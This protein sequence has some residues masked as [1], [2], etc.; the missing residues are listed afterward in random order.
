MN[1]TKELAIKALTLYK[2][3]YTEET[4]NNPEAHTELKNCR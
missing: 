2:E 1:N 3:L 4:G